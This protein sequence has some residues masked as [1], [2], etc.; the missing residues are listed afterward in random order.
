MKIKPFPSL[1]KK[2]TIELSIIT[3]T[4]PGR[5]EASLERAY[6]SILSQ[7][8]ETRFEWLIQVDGGQKEEDLVK[9]ELEKYLDP[10]IRIVANGKHLGVATTRNI[11]LERALGEA[12]CYL[13]DDDY[14]MSKAFSVWIDR[15]EDNNFI[16]SAGQMVYQFQRQELI[17]FES[18][19]PSGP[20]KPGQL[21]KAWKGPNLRFPHPPSTIAAR[22]DAVRSLG[23]WPALPQGDDLGLVLALSDLSPG[24]ISKEN[25]YVYCQHQENTMTSLGFE[26]LESVSRNIIWN[27]SASTPSDGKN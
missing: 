26:Q 19:L 5:K 25:V 10:R 20:I 18:L 6:Q 12:V 4:L 24:Y 27:R 22:I 23:G 7:S 2:R 9:K 13:D 8:R 21:F 3:A 1:A 14:L 16:W 11:A 15:L 17:Q